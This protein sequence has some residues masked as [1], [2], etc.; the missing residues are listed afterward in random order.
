MG[1]WRVAGRPALR[2]S[3]GN[4]G[5]RMH[6]EAQPEAVRRGRHGF[7][8]FV[9]RKVGLQSWYIEK[10]GFFFYMEHWDRHPSLQAFP[11]RG[12]SVCGDS[13]L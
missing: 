4:L 5:W 11:A 8:W 13:A 2:L 10:Y 12:E 6:S 1:T 3:D 9:L 7:E